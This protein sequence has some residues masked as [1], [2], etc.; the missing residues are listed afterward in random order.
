MKQLKLSEK[1]RTSLLVLAAILLFA[2]TTASSQT[3]SDLY[4]L[5]SNSGDPTSP[6]YIGAFTQG[7]DGNLCASSSSSRNGA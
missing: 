6:L 5:G 1:Q 7:R 4:N 2:A 3:Y